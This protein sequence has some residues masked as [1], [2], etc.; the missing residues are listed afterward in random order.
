VLGPKSEEYNLFKGAVFGDM[1]ESAI[2]PNGVM[3]TSRIS[4]ALTDPSY[5]NFMGQ[6]FDNKQKALLNRMAIEGQN[7]MSKYEPG[8]QSF[9]IFKKGLEAL[10]R[11]GASPID[12]VKTMLNMSG[13]SKQVADYM[14]DRGFM[15][16]MQ[17][18]QS[19]E[20]KQNILKAAELS[21]KLIS[22]MRVL[23]IESVGAK[24]EKRAFQRLAPI[25]GPAL[26]RLFGKSSIGEGLRQ[27]AGDVSQSMG[28]D[29]SEPAPSEDDNQGM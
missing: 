28:G 8:E 29:Q 4:K 26:S 16:M 10:S 14:T 21:E 27:A 11:M 13:Q 19:P 25:A 24:G 5:H 15:E 9:G 2:K 1:V 20:I 12:M 22:K 18:A 23:D 7:I 17:T 6:L 3:D